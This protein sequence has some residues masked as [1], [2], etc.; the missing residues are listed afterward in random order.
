MVT[1]DI[2]CWEAKE[3]TAAKSTSANVRIE[4]DTS[5]GGLIGASKGTKMN[6]QKSTWD[7]ESDSFRRRRDS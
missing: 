7:F 5:T 1:R 2:V 4:T 6:P 3:P